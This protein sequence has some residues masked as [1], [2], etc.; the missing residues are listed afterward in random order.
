[1]R[2][3]PAGG[4]GGAASG[5]VG[6]PVTGG[7]VSRIFSSA[8]R[9]DFGGLLPVPEAKELTPAEV[10]AA[11]RRR[12]R[13]ALVAADVQFA[14]EY[15]IN[16]GNLLLTFD[17]AEALEDADDAK[18]LKGRREY[19]G[20]LEDVF[21]TSPFE[22][23]KLQRGQVVGRSFMGS[24]LRTVG[25]FK[26]V[27]RLCATKDDPSPVD[28]SALLAPKTHVV[29]VYVLTGSRLQ[30]KDTYV[31]CGVASCAVARA[32]QLCCTV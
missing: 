9:H 23:Y 14:A 21:A 26:G 1:M 11:E 4:P 5:K 30:P 22:A 24:N 19:T 6:S 27:V 25:V 2:G 16:L 3:T 28:M 15:G 29:R 31:G 20:G 10:A 32:H 18:Y 12:R 7:V 17:A 13:D 8:L